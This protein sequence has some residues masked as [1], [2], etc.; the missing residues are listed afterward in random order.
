MLVAVSLARQ[1]P[2]VRVSSRWAL[3]V[4]VP[5]GSAKTCEGTSVV[6]FVGFFVL[7]VVVLTAVLI[8]VEG[9]LGP[10]LGLRSL[11]SEFLSPD[12]RLTPPNECDFE[13]FQCLPFGGPLVFVYNTAK[14]PPNSTTDKD[15]HED[16][17]EENKD[18]F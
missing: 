4:N 14:D 11:L 13:K 3:S 10:G 7:L 18:P 2:E 8:V 12:A 17:H 6:V 1:S 15:D 16:D 9:P 5:V